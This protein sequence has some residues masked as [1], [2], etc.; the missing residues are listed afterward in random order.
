MDGG[1]KVKRLRWNTMF[2]EVLC[3]SH[4]RRVQ[5][6][7]VQITSMFDNWDLVGCFGPF[8]EHKAE[9]CVLAVVPLAFMLGINGAKNILF[10]RY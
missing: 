3:V 8:L 10:F 4:L 6:R 7:L 2:L 5:N 9:A 1:V